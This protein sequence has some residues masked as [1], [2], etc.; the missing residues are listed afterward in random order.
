MALS[1][2]TRLGPYQILDP[3]GAGGMGEVYRARDTRLDRS[4]AVKIIHAEL[5]RDP[6]RR[7]RFEREARAI[8]AMSHPH[9]C[10]LYDVGHHEGVDFLVMELLEGK[11]LES[12]LESG[13]QGIGD[14]LVW[15]IQ[16][17]DALDKAHTSG[18]LLFRRDG[19]L[20]AQPF[21]VS[22]LRLTGSPVMIAD[23]VGFN[24]ISYQGLFSASD[25]GTI[26]YQALTARSQFV[27]FDRQG[28]RLA[29]AMPAADYSTVCLT[30]D[31]KQIVYD[32]ADPKSG[33]IDIWGFDVANARASRLTFDAAVDFMPVCS[34]AS[35]EVVFSSLREGPPSLYRQLIA[36]PGSEKPV[37]RSERAKIASDWSADGRLIVYSILNQKTNWDV[38]VLP[39][40]GGESQTFLATPAEERNARLS[41]D[42]RW[43]AYMSNETGNFEVYVQPYPATGTKW[44]ISKG[45][46]VQPQWRRDGR[47][48]FYLTADKKLLGVA[49]Q[50]GAAFVPGETRSLFDTRITGWDR[51]GGSNQ[52]AVAANGQR[53]L[54]NSATDETLSITLVRNWSSSLAR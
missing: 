24:P 28:K 37:L 29:E 40:A 33:N 20:V 27:W 15:A 6:Q 52:F 1:S 10:A 11:T 45:G 21:D 8:A 41:P 50:T 22:A 47:E 48:L 13:P 17:A 32:L 2:G 3:L 18:F 51:A 12:R 4:V 49:V 5:S 7:S 31:E 42:G 35:S 53:F 16:I 43:M 34:L 30:P 36:N 54:V 39:L 14:V 26:A 9:I 19:A 23:A 46:G 38:E 25:N 44:Q